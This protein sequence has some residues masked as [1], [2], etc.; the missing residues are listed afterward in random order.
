MAV[1]TDFVAYV[2]EQL[3]PLGHVTSRR[4]FGGV[5]LY[6]D[7]LFFGLIASDTLYFK[8][9]DSN[10]ADYE[11]RG[12][13]PFCPFPDK[14]DFSMSYYDLPADLLEDAEE[15]SRWARKSVAV[16]LAAANMKARKTMAWKAKK[17]AKKK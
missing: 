1:S 16:A 2:V 17:T 5:G 14:S 9:D 15:L 8:V 11:Q 4:M 12:S 13:K 10:R 6:A 7:D 3:G